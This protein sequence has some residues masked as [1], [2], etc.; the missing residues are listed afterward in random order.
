M[1]GYQEEERV[2]KVAQEDRSGRGEVG[3]CLEEDVAEVEGD[4]L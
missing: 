4:N 1:Q 3:V 2:L